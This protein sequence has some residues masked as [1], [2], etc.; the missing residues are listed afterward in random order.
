MDKE[1]IFALCKSILWGIY[2]LLFPILSGTF[3]AILSLG[4]IKTLF[5][6]GVFM[7]LSLVFPL[8]FIITKK[9]RWNEIGFA[10]IDASGCK[11]ALFFLPLLAIFI[12]AAVKGFY[13]DSAAYVWGNLFLYLTVGIAEEVYFRGII[14][15]YLC[16]A[17]SLKHVVFLSAAIFGLGHAASAFTASSGLEIF[18]SILNALIFG[19][20]TIEMAVICNNIAPGMLLHFLFDFETKIA[21][22]SSE[23]LIAEYIRGTIMVIAAAW[24]AGILVKSGLN[25]FGGYRTIR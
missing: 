16:K 2:I 10:E 3:S 5:L 15:R 17:F 19:W 24:L 9:W 12:P 11:K 8:L 21:V 23:L 4:K 25:K 14:P 22:I 6:Q 20:L 13:A 7:L 18:L 1:K